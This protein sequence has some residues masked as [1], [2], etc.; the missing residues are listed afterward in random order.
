MT[1]PTVSIITPTYN[2]GGFVAQCVESVIAQT[3][4]NWEML[5]V[6]D[7]S[8]DDTWSVVQ[9]YAA[10]DPR[11][12]CFHQK[13]R[14]IYR[15]AETYNFALA[16]ARGKLVAI[17]EGD[18]YWPHDKLAQQ[19]PL[20]EDADVS[21][22]YGRVFIV[23]DERISSEFHLPAFSGTIPATQCLRLLFLRKSCITPVSTVMTRKAL[24][25]IGGF[26]QDRG[27]PA[28]DYS[29]FYRYLQLPGKVT[30]HNATLGYWRQS[31]GQ[32]TKTL[33]VEFA[34][35]VLQLALEQLSVTPRPLREELGLT[36]R[37]VLKEQYR[38]GILPSYLGVL[39]HALIDNQRD[40]AVFYAQKMLTH[41]TLKQ[42]LQGL[43]G[44]T[45]ALLGTDMEPLFS[46]YE[47]FLLGKRRAPL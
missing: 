33:S 22:S 18:D 9:E 12:R 35:A 2:H 27:T 13:N 23:E 37:Q 25:K 46:S 28:V 7:G 8:T 32:V 34:E 10:Q 19:V 3:Y 17:L 4:D 14:G 15:L 6:D 5:I 42:R 29:T 36:K 16:Q 1:L 20:H 44:M 31:A 40:Q 47:K 39:R 38:A 45:A 26:H 41:G 24:L 11:I 30:W 21:M 43:Y